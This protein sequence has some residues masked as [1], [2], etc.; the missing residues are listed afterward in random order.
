M[1]THGNGDQ[2]RGGRAPLDRPEVKDL[3]TLEWIEEPDRYAGY[4]LLDPLGQKI[5]KVERVF[6]SGRGEPQYVRV[7]VGWMRSKTLFIP[8]DRVALDEA[9]RTLTLF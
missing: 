4:R 5:G 2:G 8:T 7:K 6:A 1:Q 3:K 9:L